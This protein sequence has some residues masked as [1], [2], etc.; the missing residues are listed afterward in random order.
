MKQ[1]IE[2]DKTEIASK[3]WKGVDLDGT[4]AHYEGDP[5]TIGPAVKKMLD[6]VKNWIKDGKKVKI[7]TAQ[8]GN[9]SQIPEIEDWLIANDIP[10]LQITNE[11]DEF[12][13]ELWDDGAVQVIRNT[14]DRVDEIEEAI[15]KLIKNSTSARGDG[16]MLKNWRS[17]INSMIPL[18]KE[19]KESDAAGVTGNSKF[20]SSGRLNTCSGSSISDEMMERAINIVL[21]KD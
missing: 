12:M 10:G 13:E 19:V 4:L 18:D 6:R 5:E 20:N 8:A 1:D 21:E 2:N 3:Q 14:G 15:D 9:P 7:L 16:P 11:K 17:S